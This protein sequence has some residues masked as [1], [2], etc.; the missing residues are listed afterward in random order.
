MASSHTNLNSNRC[1]GRCLCD[2]RCAGVARVPTTCHTTHHTPSLSHTHHTA[3]VPVPHE[4][5]DRQVD[6]AV[7][8]WAVRRRRHSSSSSRVS[9]GRGGSS[10]GR[11]WRWRQAAAAAA[12]GGN[13]G[14][15]QGVATSVAAA[16]AWR[17]YGQTRRH[18]GQSDGAGSATHARAARLPARHR[19]DVVWSAWSEIHPTRLITH[20][21]PCRAF[22][23][24]HSHTHTEVM[25]ASWWPFARQMYTNGDACGERKVR[26]V[27]CDYVSA[28]V[29]VRVCA[30]VC[31]CV[32]AGRCV[33]G[34][35]TRAHTRARA[36]TH[37]H[38]HT[39]THTL[40]HAR[41]PIHTRTHTSGAR[42]AR[43][44]L[45]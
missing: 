24:S 37:T 34:K 44:A 23:T 11:Q 41:T 8:S 19:C 31:L 36:H 26:R 35:H 6:R 25:L 27:V 39:S 42:Q 3:C 29:C 45:R 5:R 18:S 13:A 21:T 1:D 12:V 16:P 30:C 22:H 15:W 14:G 32:G 20:H 4:P 40:T 38:T 2:V 7:H 33:S 17:R 43:A 9:G 28:C 10:G